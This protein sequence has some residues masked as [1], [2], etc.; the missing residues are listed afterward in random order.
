MLFKVQ[1]FIR[2]SDRTSVIV[3]KNP[4]LFRHSV[5]THVRS[6][7]ESF[8]IQFKKPS[9]IWVT[10][11]WFF[12]RSSSSCNIVST[13]WKR[14]R[15]ARDTKGCSTFPIS[16][17]KWIPE[18]NKLIV[19]CYFLY[20]CILILCAACYTR[21]QIIDGIIRAWEHLMDAYVIYYSSEIRVL[22]LMKFYHSFGISSLFT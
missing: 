13:A 22:C 16:T 8:I 6:I 11:Y 12:V 4:S 9:L 18:K 1:K 15:K 17:S 14:V 2:T 5:I 10:L 19:G 20:V 7:A 21:W 3:R